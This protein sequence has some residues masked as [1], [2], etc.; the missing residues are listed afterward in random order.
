ARHAAD[1]SARID[2]AGRHEAYPGLAVTL[3]HELDADAA[4]AVREIVISSTRDRMRQALEPQLFEARE[5]LLVM[6]VSEDGVHPT[7]CV[8]AAAAA[9]ERQD[10][11]CE[12]GVIKIG[13]GSRRALSRRHTFDKASSGNWFSHHYLFSAVVGLAPCGELGFGL[14]SSGI[15]AED[16]APFAHLLH[17]EI[18]VG[19][20]LVAFLGDRVG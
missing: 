9:H 17:H 14:G 5:E 18:L 3:L 4:N 8:A 20:H 2:P 1:G 15:E 6:L 12:V 10:D 16:A 13:D 7:R 19:R 11:A